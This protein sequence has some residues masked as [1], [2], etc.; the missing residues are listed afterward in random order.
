MIDIDPFNMCVIIKSPYHNDFL[1]DGTVTPQQNKHRHILYTHFFHK[2]LDPNRY[3]C[4]CLVQQGITHDF[5]KIFF[6]VPLNW[7]KKL[8]FGLKLR[9]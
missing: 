9:V 5:D 6:K 7:P 4:G 2:Q 1:T 8:N 3:S